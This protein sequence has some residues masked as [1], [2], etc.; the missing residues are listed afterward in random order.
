[1]HAKSFTDLTVK[2]IPSVIPWAETQQNALDKLKE[3]LSKA[4]MDSLNIVDFEKPFNIHVDASDYAVG[5]VVSQTD[6]KGIEQPITFA[7]QKLNNTQRGWSTVEKESY[8]AMW[9]LQKYRN[10]LFAA[11]IVIFCDHNPVVYLTE[12]CSKSA[13]L[14][15]WALAIQEFDVK[16]CYKPGKNNTAADYLSRPSPAGDSE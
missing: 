14:M 15:R 12:A 4:T 13:K 3:L 11:K 6:E 5:A 16:F 7:S 1:M 9:T 8:A 10:W 2:K